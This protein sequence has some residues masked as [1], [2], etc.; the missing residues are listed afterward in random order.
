MLSAVFGACL[1]FYLVYGPSTFSPSTVGFVLAISCK[2]CITLSYTLCLMNTGFTVS[3]TDEI[4]AW[5]RVFNDIEGAYNT[6]K[7]Q[8]E[9]HADVILKWTG[10]GMHF[11]FDSGPVLN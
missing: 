4:L 10:I 3:L 5:V 1:A 6:I 11:S 8:S 9:L 2:C 7:F